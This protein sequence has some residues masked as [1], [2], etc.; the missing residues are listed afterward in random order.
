MK[1]ISKINYLISLVVVVSVASSCK[2]AATLDQVGNGTTTTTTTPANKIAPDGFN[3]NTTKQVAVSVRLLSI[4]NQPLKNVMVSLAAPS[5]RVNYSGADLF[6]AATDGNGYVTASVTVPSQLDTLVI[7]PAYTGIIQDSKALISNNSINVVLGGTAIASGVLKAST[8]G[9]PAN[10]NQAN[11]RLSTYGA[12]LTTYTYMGKYDS[13]GAP[14]DYKVSPSDVIS[15]TFMT[16]LNASLPEQKDVRKLHPSYIASGTASDLKIVQKADVWI[17]FAYEGAGNLNSVGYYTYSTNTPPKTAADI[18]QVY[19]MFPNSSMPYSGGNL[20]QGTKVKL[21]TFDAGTS[22]GFV[23]FGSGWTGS[24]VNSNA[25]KFY[26]TSNLNPE[27]GD[28]SRHTVLLNDLK[29]NLFLIGFEDLNRTTSGCDHDFN[30]VV[31]YATSNP[32]TAISTD[33]VAPVDTPVDSDGDGVSDTFDAFPNDPTRAYISY[34]PSKDNWGTLAYEDQWPLKGDYDMNDL[35]VNYRYTTVSNAQNNVVEMTGDYTV[36]AA[37]AS[38]NNGFAVQFP[39]SASSVKQVTGQRLTSGYIKSAGNGVES[40]QQKAVIV[41]FDSYRSMVQTPS[42]FINTVPTNARFN[43][44]TVHV[45]MQFTAP[46]TT[47][48]L[49]SAPFNPFLISN[50]HRGFEVHLPSNT[51]TDLAEM[52]IFGTQDDTSVPAA[53]RYYLS[54]DNHP[55][56]MSFYQGFAYPTEGSPVWAAYPHFLDWAKSGGTQFTDWY[57]NTA[58]GYRDSNY[59]FSK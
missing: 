36:L 31:L 39:F 48:T 9:V 58:L 18:K 20:A 15:S 25:P 45:Y 27:P 14:T 30:D 22:I 59:I 44:D 10:A 23:L 49:G 35:V 51:P 2:K 42:Y 50:G 55:W 33:N 29:E 17:T 8:T 56:A 19:Y 7:K 28:L 4:D 13:Y 54:Q 3:F 52:T 26:S 5:N 38:Y 11:G 21:G 12:D 47:A 40:G 46:I 32:V 24:V 43:S 34:F 6:K 57:S 37:G 41:P 1:K 16:Y 53:G